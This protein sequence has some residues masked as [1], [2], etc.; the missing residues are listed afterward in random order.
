MSLS[1]GCPRCPTPIAR[2]APGGGWSC[3]DHGAIEP[4]WRPAEA[5][6][7]GFV[8][9]LGTAGV[10]PSYLPWPMSP[11]WAVTDFGVVGS[12]QGQ[13]SAT[14]TCCSG[15]SELDGPVDVLVV[16][17]EPGTGL[18]ARCAG[19][20]A[21]DPGAEIGD[22]PATV[23]VRL[24]HQAVGLWPVSTSAATG[25]WDRSVVAGEARGRWLWLVLRPA[26]AILL[27]RDDWILRDV[28]ALGPGLVETAFGGPRPS[29]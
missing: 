29:W 14:M 21:L 6:Y 24:D 25:E 2:T 18:G 5:S 16:T 20:S 19:T 12:G 1:A 10:F 7:A 15:T 23:K 28:S 26:S 13:V 22:G 11:G 9:H 17:E 3:P 4:L 8:E 27:L